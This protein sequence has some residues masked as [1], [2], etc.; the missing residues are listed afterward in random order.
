MLSGGLIWGEGSVMTI[1]IELSEAQVEKLR[2][3]AQRLGVEP[4]ALAAAAVVDLLNRE[5]LDFE[6]AAE[7]VIQKNRELYKRLS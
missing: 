7:Y 2:D 3:Q 6:Q 5:A 1:P 4:Q